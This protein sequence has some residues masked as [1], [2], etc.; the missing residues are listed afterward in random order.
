MA[1]NVG[2]P[3]GFVLDETAG[4]AELPDGFQI[5]GPSINFDRPIADVRA[6]IA[7]VPEGPERDAILKDWAKTYVAKER[8]GNTT[9]P[10]D[11]V[12]RNFARGTIVGSFADEAN[13]GTSALLHKITGG[14]V[15]APYDEAIAYQRALDDAIDQETGATATKI[16]GGLASGAP[17]AKAA[18]AGAKTLTG[19]AARS[20]A[21]GGTYGGVAGLGNAEGYLEDRID[22]AIRGAMFGA[23]IGAAVPVVGA[24]VG[25]VATKAYEA[26]SPTLARWGAQISALPERV[27]LPRLSADG[28][29]PEPAGARAAAEQIIANQLMRANRSTDDLR[30]VLAGADEARTFHSS[31]VAQSPLAIVD[32]DPSLARLAGSVNRAS[33]EASG[34]MQAFNYARRTGLTPDG[35]LPPEAGIPHKPMMGKPLLGR[36]AEKQFG[37]RFDTPEDAAV[38]AGQAERISDALKRAFRIEDAAAHGHAQN[39]YRTEQMMQATLKKEADKLYPTAW[40]QA[41]DFDL[42]G[43]FQGLRTLRDEINDPGARSV[44]QRAERLFTSPTGNGSPLAS[45]GELRRFDLAKQR[46]DG[47][48]D[49]YKGGDTFLYRALA[50]FKNDVLDSVHGG[51]R[52]NPTINKKYAEARDW[53]SSQKEAQEAIDLGRSAFKGDADVGIDTYRSLET[54]GLRKLFRLGMWSAYEGAA[55]NM[56]RGGDVTRMFDNPRIQELLG[57]VIPR[58]KSA[59]GEFANRPERFGQYLGNEKRMVRTGNEAFGNSKTAERIVDDKAF[60]QMSALSTAVERFRQSGSVVNIGIQA[61]EAALHKLFGMRADTAASIAR[62]IFTADPQARLAVLRNIEARMG[63]TRFEHFSRLLQEQQSR[64]TAAGARAATLPE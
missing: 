7:K 36:D 58:T 9:L 14:R 11:D 27:G 45:A 33:P 4:S 60:E 39:A 17:I 59:S 22:P 3:D 51:D 56:P 50:K 47:L 5:D 31:G 18:L 28:A 2:L 6:D 43:A 30:N 26:A 15:G 34:Q 32:L 57:A 63:P 49:R 54:E 20:A 10:L 12:V 35:P 37:T 23:P 24:G 55:K 1:T 44:L 38:P 42:S 48:I 62:Q 16:A 8:A 13:A 19:K 21:F 46:L 25:S 52:I 61:A 64:L 29:V 53:Y 40:K 41:D